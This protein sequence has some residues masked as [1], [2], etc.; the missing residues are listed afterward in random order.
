M[1]SAVLE[2]SL[3]SRFFFPHGSHDFF[4]YLLFCPALGFLGCLLEVK[5]DLPGSCLPCLGD[6]CSSLDTG[7]GRLLK[8]WPANPI[9]FR[10]ICYITFA[11]VL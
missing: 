8:K 9:L 1:A 5:T 4:L 7:F 11:C 6:Q 3:L 2:L 10:L